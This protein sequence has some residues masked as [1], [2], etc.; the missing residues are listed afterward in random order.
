MKFKL[1]IIALFMGQVVFAQTDKPVRVLGTKCSIVPPE[2]FIPATQFYGFMDTKTGSS[3]RIEEMPVPYQAY[4]D[5]F[6]TIIASIRGLTLIDKDEID[7]NHSKALLTKVRFDLFDTSIFSISLV[8]GNDDETVYVKGNYPESD[9]KIEENIR[10]ALLS[11]QYDTLLNDN[12]TEAASFTVD[13]TGTEFKCVKF[14]SGSLYFLTDGRI[15]KEDPRIRI[16]QSFQKV[17]PENR[18]QFAKDRLNHL[19]ESYQLIVKDFKAITIDHLEGYEILAEGSISGTE[20]VSVYQLV[21]FTE[22]GGYYLFVGQCEKDVKQCTEE[23]R[24]IAMTFKRK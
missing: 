16:D 6:E 7:F 18:K 21:L 24:K 17:N 15:G 8:F 4:V 14:E 22:S 11:T 13:L 9:K 5:D 3:I 1:L 12:P 2:G 20:I 10:K 19:Q 23:F